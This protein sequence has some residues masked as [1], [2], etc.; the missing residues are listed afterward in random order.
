MKD[1]A[2]QHQ[3]PQSLPDLQQ[4][5]SQAIANIDVSQLQHTWKEFDNGIEIGRVANGEHVEY[6]KINLLSFHSVFKLS[7][8][9]ICNRFGN[10]LIC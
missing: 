5:S 8:V 1:Q 2:C 3:T 9:C 7:H 4:R 10:T 6:R